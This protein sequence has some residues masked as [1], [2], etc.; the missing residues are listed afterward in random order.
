MIAINQLHSSAKLFFFLTF[1]LLG[2]N[3]KADTLRNLQ[4]AYPDN[5]DRVTSS[6]IACKDGTR[7]PID[8][9]ASV[10][11]WLTGSFYHLDNSFGSI[12]NKEL[13]RDI[14]EPFFRKMYGNS[15]HEVKKKLVKIYWM[16]NVFGTR[17]PLNVTTVNDVNKKLLEVSNELEQLPPSY[18]KYL[19]NPAPNFYWRSVAGEN[20]LSMHSFGIAID[21]NVHYSNYW[22]WDFLK[23]KRPISDLRY[24]KLS[25]QNKIPQK[26]VQIFA[27]HGFF[28]GGNWYF[29]DTMHFEYRPE[30]LMG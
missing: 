10:I 3:A 30:L 29:Y 18:Y 22:L 25:Y 9:S 7:I 11:D 1:L 28:W 26:I 17:Y 14:Y 8:N 19:E 24:Y 12:S 15:A 13:S 16:Q 6:F 23:L 20:Y 4:K 27:K 21:I 2:I 5:V